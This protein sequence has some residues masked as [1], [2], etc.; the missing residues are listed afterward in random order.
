MQRPFRWNIAKR[1]QLGRL[2]GDCREIPPEALQE[3]R[4][5]TA[6]I[7]AFCDNAD[8]VFVGRS[9]ETVFDYLSGILGGTSWQDRLSLLNVSLQFS[10]LDG[11]RGNRKATIA[12]REQL[13]WLHLSPSQIVRRPRPIALVDVV[14]TGHT[15]GVLADLLVTWATEERA[16]ALAVKQKMRF[17]GLTEKKKTSPN[18]W[19]W[20]QQNEWTRQFPTSAIKNTS[21]D[22]QKFWSAY[23]HPTDRVAAENPPW[24][25]GDDTVQQAPRDHANF[26]ALQLALSLYELGCSPRE[27]REFTKQLAAEPGM[28]HGWYRDVITEVR[29]TA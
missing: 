28:R 4:R 11:I 17:V 13:G 10:S 26:R 5:C 9:L 14:A 19:R 2:P 1:E 27:K 25:W 3:I 22:F 18:T 15:F 12:F 24:R 23:E 29:K 7:L 6:R 8:L 20:Q 16:D 21:V